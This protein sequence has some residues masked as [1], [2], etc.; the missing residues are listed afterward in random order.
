MKKL[1]FLYCFLFLLS[2]SHISSGRYVEIESRENLESISKRYGV[3]LAL[4]KKHNEGR[5]ISPGKWVF[6]PWKKGILAG[7]KESSLS[8]LKKRGL[9]AKKSGSSTSPERK[10]ASVK[11]PEV[12]KRRRGQKF[13]WP[14]PK[15]SKISSLY[16]KRNG[17]NHDGIDIPAPTGTKIIAAQEGV[18]VYSGN[19]LRGYGNLTIISHGEYLSVYAHAKKNLKRK[20]DKVQKGEMIALVGSTGRS[21][22]PHLHF[23]I[24]KKNKPID[25]LNFYR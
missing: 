6:I 10:L 5:E 24:R 15:H 21:S 14:V 16:G 7:G 18:V 4:L 25:P 2:C 8:A 13:L 1:S 19:K 20:G 22:G 9:L 11:L 17:R 23:E 3:S 12:K